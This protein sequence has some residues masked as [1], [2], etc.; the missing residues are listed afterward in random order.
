VAAKIRRELGIDVNMLRGGYG[1]FKI[2]VDDQTVIDGG[3]WGALGMLPSGKKV[4]E[5]V[6]SRL[7]S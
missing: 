3:A 4:V 1:E 5:M 2:L 6:R 7:V